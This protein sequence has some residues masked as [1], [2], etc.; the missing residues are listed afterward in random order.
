[1]ARSTAAMWYHI[2]LVSY[3]GY[4]MYGGT[5]TAVVYIANAQKRVNCAAYIP[6]LSHRDSN[7]VIANAWKEHD[8]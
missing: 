2:V 6:C 4:D 8:D 7:P 3:R 5:C 1:M